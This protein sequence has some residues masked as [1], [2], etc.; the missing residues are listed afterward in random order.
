MKRWLLIALWFVVLFA[1][2][3]IVKPSLHPDFGFAY[4]CLEALGQMTSPAKILIFVAGVVVIWKLPW[5]R[6][7]HSE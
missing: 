3:L 1:W 5:E 7:S 6:K 2:N 4:R